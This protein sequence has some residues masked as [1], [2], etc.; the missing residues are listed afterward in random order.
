MRA[1]MF[2]LVPPRFR[3]VLTELGFDAPTPIQSAALPPLLAGR[4]LVGRAPTGSGK[5]LAFG[6]PLLSSLD[7][8][9]R[10][11]QAL[12]VCPTR[13]L[14]SQVAGALRT[15]GRRMPGLRVL[16]AAGGIPGGPQRQALEE[17]VHVVVGTPGRLV[18]HLERGS[19]DPRSV[20]MLVL[21][22]ADR[23]LEMGFAEDM[24]RVLRALPPRQ[25][26][27]FSATFP[28]D[29]QALASRWLNDPAEVSVG[30]T[31]APAALR[32]LACLVPNAAPPADEPRVDPAKVDV[33]VPLLRRH[34]RALVFCNFKSSATALALSLV[35]AGLA[36]APF[37]GDLDQ[38]A[39]DDVLAALRNGTLRVLVATDVAARGLD[40][41]GLDLVVNA[42]LPPS[43]EVYVHRVGRTARAGAAGLAVSL[44]GP[45]EE[46]RLAAGE[47]LAGPVR[48]VEATTLLAGPEVAVRPMATL[49]IRAGR[50]D[51]LRAGDILGALT[52]DAGFSATDIGRI[53]IAD[54][55]TWVGVAQERAAEMLE[56]LGEGKV[57]GRRFRVE[58]FG[59]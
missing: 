35:D 13:E 56:W 3:P 30:V 24:E 54:R 2:D 27:L 31:E 1:A 42:E 49:R 26:A 46:R 45:R 39:R 10:G 22:E 33:L 40:V 51:K 29:I 47:A 9:Q 16:V 34:P 21:D 7:S 12:V 53:E 5:T 8:S 59:S 43:P 44:V 11:P 52:A 14:A 4:D 20:R 32:Q 36:A 28:P 15:F 17:G 58:G 19:L 18:D 48:R 23:M 6:I 50:K 38:P 25:T 55:V 41:E 57:K 37:H